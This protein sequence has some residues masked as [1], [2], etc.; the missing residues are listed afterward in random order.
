M[1]TIAEKGAYLNET[2]SQLKTAINNLGGSIDSET[3]FRE[4]V[5]E[6]EGVYDNY[7]KTSYGEGTSVI[8]TGCTKGKLDFEDDK[9]GY[10]DTYQYTT[11]GYNLFDIDNSVVTPDAI[12]DTSKT[13][14]G[15]NFTTISTIEESAYGRL[16]IP[17]DFVSSD[18]TYCFSFDITS[19]ST[20][21]IVGWMGSQKVIVNTITANTKTH[22]F[23]TF[24]GITTTVFSIGIY[25]PDKITQIENFQIF[26]GSTDKAYEP[27]TNGASPNPSYPQPIEVVRGKN[28]IN[29][30]SARQF[31]TNVKKG[32]TYT[33]SFKGTAIGD[34]R[35]FLRTYNG[36]YSVTLDSFTDQI[37][38]Q[39]DGTRQVG[40]ITSTIDGILYIRS[41]TGPVN[42]TMEYIQIEKGTQA[43]S[44]L[45]YNTL[46][47]KV[48][49]KNLIPNN[50]KQGMISV[51]DGKTIDQNNYWVYTEDYISIDSQ[52]VVSFKETCMA[53][54]FLY[55][56]NKNFISNYQVFR[57][58]PY[59]AFNHPKQKYF[60]IGYN[61]SG[62]TEATT[63]TTI[64]THE[65]IAEYG[66]TPTSYVKHQ[67]TTHQLSLGEYEFA[68]I[69]NYVDTIEYDVENDKVYKNENIVKQVVT[70]TF[71]DNLYTFML[72]SI[73]DYGIANF[74]LQYVSNSEETVYDF[75]G[76]CNYLSAQTSSI[77]NEQNE[78]ILYQQRAV[79]I[80]IKSTTAS[81]TQELKTYVNSLNTGGN[82]L[83][84][85]RQL[86]TPTKTEI[87]GTLKDQIKALYNSH[88]FTGTT[89]IEINGNLPMIMKCRALKGE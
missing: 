21:I 2:K 76:L 60:R 19:N 54:V 8:L 46:E 15:F 13:S 77:A 80:R 59:G 67:E 64:Y 7:P 47:V 68:K 84:I 78:G 10:G 42:I 33:I 35:L 29:Y 58:I 49:N 62:T 18:K 57:T 61:L 23:A 43:T 36:E 37:T 26:E 12:K 31:V 22:I 39:L 55:D 71:L 89:I 48:S 25:G 70:G 17:T 50:W 16:M 20:K 24:S 9:V 63:P 3:T 81:T 79:Y 52:F 45:P 65:P 6:L 11:Q 86:L 66:N 88:S 83:I 30:T 40:T 34:T 32:D 1:G 75:T 5:E 87:T 41:A 14:T 27:Y 38:L 44:Y 82:P 85:Y 53:I 74:L 4:Y 69:G 73:N 72:Q 56:E 28:L 51:N